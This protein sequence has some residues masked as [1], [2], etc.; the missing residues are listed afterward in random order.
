MNQN[1]GRLQK[2]VGWSD[3]EYAAGSLSAKYSVFSGS[4]SRNLNKNIVS[5]NFDFYNKKDTPLYR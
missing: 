3:F 2:V 5:D 1:D 4:S